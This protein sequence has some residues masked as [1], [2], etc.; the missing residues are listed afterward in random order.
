MARDDAQWVDLPIT[1]DPYPSVEEAQLDGISSR[2]VD[3]YVN[4]FDQTVKRPCLGSIG[5]DSTLFIDSFPVDGIYWWSAKRLYVVMVYGYPHIFSE[6]FQEIVLNQPTFGNLY[7]GVPVQFA[8]DGNTL[9]MAN[10]KRML[11]TSTGLVDFIADVDAPQR[12]SHV[13]YLDGYMLCNEVGTG[14]FYRSAL[15]DYSSW[16]PIDF[17][18]AE[19]KP[20][21]IDG[22]Y[23]GWNEIA[24]VG[25]ESVEFW[26]NDGISPF[27]RLQGGIVN[28]GCAAVYTFKQVGD[29]WMML[30]HQ[31]RFVRI[32]G[33]N[34]EPVDF[35]MA[36]LVEQFPRVD[37]A[38]SDVIPIAGQLFYVTSF[39]AAQKTLVYN[40]YRKQWSEWSWY[41][42]ELARREHW[43]GRHFARA[44]SAPFGII[45]D[46]LYGHVRKLSR[47]A[48]S[49]VLIASTSPVAS[50]QRYP[51]LSLRRTGFIT[52][53]TPARKR[54]YAIRLRVLRQAKLGSSYTDQSALDTPPVMTVKYRDNRGAWSNERQVSIGRPGE[55]E[56]V[57]ELANWGTYY[58]RQW[59]F[60]HSDDSDWVLAEAKELVEVLPR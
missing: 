9:V 36:A 35:P 32:I 40:V 43:R 6:D 1:G 8:T 28:Q 33:R 17:A 39:P 49:D 5:E 25:R 4:E 10:G 22:L 27:S 20:D 24:L 37:D 30:N 53:N 46:R 31:R 15:F 23:V 18:T 50:F 12:V 19:G 42:P 59:E 21:I 52:H 2:I 56:I 14:R 11:Y 60:A 26:Y 57:I 38:I 51:V 3:A 48:F 7:Q 54:C 44:E 34:P 45:G 47:D 13:A 16:T 29:A 41:N 58:T 55:H